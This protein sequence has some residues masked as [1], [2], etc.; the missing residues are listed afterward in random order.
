MSRVLTKTLKIKVVI[1]SMHWLFSGISIFQQK[2]GLKFQSLA[3]RVE[4]THTS[5]LGTRK[6]KYQYI[7]IKNADNQMNLLDLLEK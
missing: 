6:K 4:G 2:G 3:P 7:F 1:L 5:Q